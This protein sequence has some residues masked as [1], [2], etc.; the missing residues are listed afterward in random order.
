MSAVLT[1]SIEQGVAF[2]ETDVKAKEEVLGRPLSAAY[3]SFVET[4]G[5]A[6][7]GGLVDGQARW[8]VLA[9]LS[10]EKIISK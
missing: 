8:P 10:A 7:V 5:A 6:F 3:R 2:T 1:V 9:F 4:T